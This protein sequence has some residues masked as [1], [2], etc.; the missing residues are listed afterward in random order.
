MHT[1]PAAAFDIAPPS[2]YD[3][4]DKGMAARMRITV[5]GGSGFIGTHLVAALRDAG[6]AVSIV[7]KLPSARFPTLVRIGDV[8]DADA[9]HAALA[10]CDCAIDLAAEHRDDVRPP[11]LYDEVN[12]GGA[13]NIV[14]AARAHGVRRLVFVSSVAV[15]G[16]DQPLVDESA[17]LRPASPYGRSK[18]AAEA[19]YRAWAATA[20]GTHSLLVLRPCVVF[21]EGNRGNVHTLIDHLQRRRFVMVGRG[22]NRKSM[23]YVGNLVAFLCS[24]LE[25]DPGVRTLNYADKPDLRTDD[26]VER[27]RALL[28][29]AAPAPPR[30]PYALALAG[31]FVFDALTALRGKPSAIG[32]A[33]IRRFRADT[34]VSTHALQQLG[35]RPP[36]TLDEGLQRMIASMRDGSADHV[37]TPAP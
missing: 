30:V 12:V 18:V 28:P 27:I 23:A 34:T 29:N 22:D 8:R 10:D 25:P 9:M 32:S 21:G 33:R 13:R 5:I 17:P 15:Y 14:A 19:E 31:G 16:L 36:W 37:E 7:D 24:Q 4:T 26:L 3:T 6:H 1:A 35:F 20:P 2:N 11:S